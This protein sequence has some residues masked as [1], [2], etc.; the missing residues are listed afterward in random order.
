MNI[1]T[2]NKVVVA[3]ASIV[4]LALIPSCASM[5]PEYA[6]YKQQQQAQAAA[7]ANPYGVPAAGASNPY[8]VPGA[9]GETGAPYQDIPGVSSTPPV[10]YTPPP[11]QP[12]TPLPAEPTG[13]ATTHIVEKGDTIWG[14]TRKYS[15]TEEQLRQTNN[16]STDTIWVGQRLVIP[17]R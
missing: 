9:G 4:S 3:G 1:Q 17:A 6:A 7:A 8:A 2:I 11:S 15:V 14:L 16:L 13:S 5:D 12:Y 10:E